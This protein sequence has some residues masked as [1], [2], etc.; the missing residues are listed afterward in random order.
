M[1]V[2]IPKPPT[3]VPPPEKNSFYK[4]EGSNERSNWAKGASTA[5]NTF[6]RIGNLMDA[7]AKKKD[8][9]RQADLLVREADAEIA[10]RYEYTGRIWQNISDARGQTHAIQ[11]ANRAETASGGVSVN[12]ETSLAAMDSVA[13]TQVTMELRAEHERDYNNSLSR[14]KEQDLRKQA[15]DIRAKAKKSTGFLK[16]ALAIGGTASNIAMSIL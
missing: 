10:Q 4:N 3:P 13:R 14:Q 2:V 9:Y 5:G 1:G 8:A 7:H 11:G 16:T 12:D 6:E 15:S